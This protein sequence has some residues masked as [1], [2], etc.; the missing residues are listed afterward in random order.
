MKPKRNYK[1]GLTID[2]CQTPSYAL[3]PILQ[4]LN[5]AWR[6]WEPAAGKGRLVRALH[7]RGFNCF[8]SD[9]L[10]GIDFFREPPKLFD[11]ILTNPPYSI[12]P[13]WTQR[14]YDLGR[15]WLLLM[16]VEFI[17]T[18]K[19]QRMFSQYGMEIVLMDKRVDFEMPHKGSSGSAQ[20]PVAWYT[21]GLNI[22]REITYTILDKRR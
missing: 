20:F 7:H 22:G 15:P 16:P 12:K 5:P 8:G 21:W 19:A 4:Y 17:G 2:H 18:Q 11:C 14:C 9:I 13:Q 10:K 6:I 3:E 1:P